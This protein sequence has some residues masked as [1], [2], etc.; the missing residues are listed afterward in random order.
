MLVVEIYLERN[1]AAFANS[2]D[3]S[4]WAERQTAELI[5]SVLVQERTHELGSAVLAIAGALFFGVAFGRVLQLVYIRGWSLSLVQTT[6]RPGD[7]TASS[8]SASTG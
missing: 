2:A 6:G 3:P 4:L 8:C 7:A 1:P 5:R